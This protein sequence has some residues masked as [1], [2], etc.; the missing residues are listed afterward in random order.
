ML[1]FEHHP[2]SPAKKRISASDPPISPNFQQCFSDLK[3]LY[4]I[5]SATPDRFVTS[6]SPESIV[7]MVKFVCTWCFWRVF[8]WLWSFSAALSARDKCSAE[9][10]S[11][12]GSSRDIRGDFWFHP[13]QVLSVLACVPWPCICI[14]VYRF[15]TMW[16][17]FSACSFL[18]MESIYVVIDAWGYSLRCY[19]FPSPS[20]TILWCPTMLFLGV[21]FRHIWGCSSWPFHTCL[22][23]YFNSTSCLNVYA[24][25]KKEGRG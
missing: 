20:V 6:A 13:C 18:A 19:V 11:L 21:N 12:R 1:A 4:K 2:V 10:K 14:S 17:E 24:W 23:L 25:G 16:G 7:Y 9:S 5:N 8:G 3:N 22:R 15:M